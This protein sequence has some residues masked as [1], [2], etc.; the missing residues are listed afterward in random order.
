MSTRS[1]SIRSSCAREPEVGDDRA[2]VTRD[3]H[4]LRLDVA[5]DEPGLMR[6][7]DAVGGTEETCED[8]V[9]IARL[10]GPLPQRHAVDELH[11]EPDFF[12]FG[13][14]VVDVA[15]V[16]MRE[17]RERLGFA[18]EPR[19]TLRVIAARRTTLIASGR[20]SCGSNA[21]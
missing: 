1:G 12:A 20:A 16:R 11:R 7:G 15:D 6:G 19:A 3:E 13:P 10:V 18:N 5:M 2:A 14:D 4:V 8:L 17:P 9:A 21:R